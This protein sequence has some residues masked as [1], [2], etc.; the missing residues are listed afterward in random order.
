MRK[1]SGK[2]K[3]QYQEKRLIFS[4]ASIKEVPLA[5][6]NKYKSMR[7]AFM[8]NMIVIIAKKYKN[9]YLRKFIQVDLKWMNKLG[10]MK[11]RKKKNRMC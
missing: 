3:Q 5:Y 6:R 4:M 7:I 1:I 11:I 2:T 10:N 9:H 8:I